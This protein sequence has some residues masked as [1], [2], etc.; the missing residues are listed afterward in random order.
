LA[1]WIRSF[2]PERPVHYEGAVRDEFGQGPYSLESLQ[3]GRN[4]SDFVSTM[5]PPIELLE[6]WATTTNDSRPF[7]M[8]EYAH[9]MGNSSG[10]LADYWATIE[11]HPGLQG[12]YIWDWVDQGLAAKTADGQEYWAYGGDFGDAPSD[13]DFCNDGLVFPDR[14][15][16]PALAECAKLFQP[17]VASSADP[18]SGLLTVTSRYDFITTQDIEARWS[19]MADGRI[20]HAGTMNLPA[21]APGASAILDLLIP[22][23]DGTRQKISS[24]ECFLMTEFFRRNATSWAPAGH[25]VAWEQIPLS[26]GSTVSAPRSRWIKAHEEAS[27]AW[28]LGFNDEGFLSS[29][30]DGTMEYLA[31]PL[32]MNLWRAPTEN[33]G[34]KNFVSLRG[35]PEFAFYYQNKAMLQW[36]DAGLDRLVFSL[37]SL[38]GGRVLDGTVEGVVHT[39]HA[40]AT[41]NGVRVGSFEQRWRSRP[42]G[43][44]ASFEFD[45]DPGLPELPRVGLATALVPGFEQVSWYGRGPEECYSDR[46]TGTPVGLYSST[47]SDLGVPYILPQ[48]NG[49]RT[50][51]QALSLRDANGRTLDI[52]GY[53]S[54][55]GNSFDFTASHVSA[56]QLWA[57]KHWYQIK[58]QAESFLYL[59]VAQRGLGTAS[60]GPDTL[61]R[62]RLRPGAYRLELSFG[63]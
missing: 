34:L 12:G 56:D 10:G 45:L 59:D 14:S 53:G 39:R 61:E 19:V 55:T 18:A 15:V 5:Y 28:R 43:P 22:W 50:D 13:L 24:A 48:E 25:R 16:K 38:E 40:V 20:I 27:S 31:A 26:P 52:A 36:L 8:C 32:K 62:Y 21:L 4:A 3:R 7:I 6:A 46:K 37:E 57:A 29:L 33:D 58:P 63:F 54:A 49:N 60:C 11:K 17:I 42:S 51:V 44:Q 30:S 1:G 47:V 23:S 9:A 2:D 41:A 35:I